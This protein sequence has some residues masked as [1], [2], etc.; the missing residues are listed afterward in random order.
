ME[1]KVIQSVREE[2]MEKNN[3]ELCRRL[4]ETIGLK[5]TANPA[6]TAA[7]KV[8]DNSV[9]VSSVKLSEGD[10]IVIEEEKPIA[11]FTSFLLLILNIAH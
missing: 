4:S 6:S 8:G 9:S 10:G 3:T 11:V 2:R 5:F 1:E 7:D